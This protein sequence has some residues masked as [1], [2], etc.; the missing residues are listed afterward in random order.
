MVIDANGIKSQ[1]G[2]LQMSITGNFSSIIM[3]ISLID[4]AFH[5]VFICSY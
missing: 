1:D 3:I 4:V 2:A 5:V